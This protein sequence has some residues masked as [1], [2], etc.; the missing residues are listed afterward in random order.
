M[1]FQIMIHFYEQV[2][3]RFD[4]E[5]SYEI[6]PLEIYN[7]KLVVVLSAPQHISK[8]VKPKRRRLQVCSS[9]LQTEKS[10]SCTRRQIYKVPAISSLFLKKDNAVNFLP[11]KK[12]YLKCDS[13]ADG[14]IGATGELFQK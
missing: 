1:N 10:H 8:T 5:Y 14:Y 13:I 3:F 11:M 4:N 12:L 2:S 9:R 7:Y 6:L